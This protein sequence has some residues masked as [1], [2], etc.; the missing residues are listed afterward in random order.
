MPASAIVGECEAAIA[1]FAFPAAA[2]EA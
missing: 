1:D 2:A